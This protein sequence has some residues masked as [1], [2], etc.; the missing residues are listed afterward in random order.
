MGRS[1]MAQMPKIYLKKFKKQR[2]SLIVEVSST[3][4]TINFYRKSSVTNILV[5][6]PFVDIGGHVI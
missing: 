2:W 5:R 6:D 3:G 4:F 1:K